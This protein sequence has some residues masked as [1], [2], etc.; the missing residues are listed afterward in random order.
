MLLL[1]ECLLLF[2]FIYQLNPETF[3]DILVCGLVLV[4][5]DWQQ[6]HFRMSFLE[7]TLK[8]SGWCKN[9]ITDGYRKRNTLVCA[10]T[11]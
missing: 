11:W 4:N 10:V 1:N 5:D 8:W 7:V 2:L 6:T 3:G 9:Y